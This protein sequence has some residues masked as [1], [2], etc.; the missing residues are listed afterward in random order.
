LTALSP[1]FGSEHD[2]PARQLAEHVEAVEMRKNLIG[3]FRGEGTSRSRSKLE[4]T[5]DE[6]ESNRHHDQRRNGGCKTVEMLGLSHV[7]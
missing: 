6:T 1:H 7:L 4:D 2:E 3:G 5:P